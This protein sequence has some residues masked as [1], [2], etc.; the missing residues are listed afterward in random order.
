MHHLPSFIFFLQYQIISNT[1]TIL[2]SSSLILFYYLQF[3]IL[4]TVRM[5]ALDILFSICFCSS[6]SSMRGLD[7]LFKFIYFSAVGNRFKYRQN[8]CFRY[9]IFIYFSAVPNSFKYRQNAC[10]KDIVFIFF[11]PKPLNQ[12]CLHIDLFLATPLTITLT[13]HT[14]H[15]RS[16]ISP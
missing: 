2:N 5:H 4:N 9:N 16:F 15:L 13:C 10:F 12:W 6:K 7:T 8:A 1:V 11:S 14:A 3:Q